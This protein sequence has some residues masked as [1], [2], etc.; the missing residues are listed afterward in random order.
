MRL[1]Q[2]HLSL[3]N[4]WSTV[5]FIIIFTTFWLCVSILDPV[6][7]W[8][9]QWY[10]SDVSNSKTS[11]EFTRTLWRAAYFATL[12]A[13]KFNNQPNEFWSHLNIS[14]NK[15]FMSLF[16]HIVFIFTN[17]IQCPTSLLISRSH[18]WL[19]NGWNSECFDIISWFLIVDFM[20]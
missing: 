12:L 4:S 19:T 7:V 5:P 18:L 16:L 10:G 13:H 8:R 20:E 14:S 1:L 3:H 11:E 6:E 17:M 15:V 9:P 2:Y